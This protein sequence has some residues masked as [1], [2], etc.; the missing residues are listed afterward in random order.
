[1]KSPMKSKLRS[2]A[3]VTPSITPYT[4][5]L[6]L[7]L[8]VFGGFLKRIEPSCLFLKQIQ[9]HPIGNMHKTIDFIGDLK[10]DGCFKWHTPSHG[11][12]KCQ[13]A[14]IFGGF[15]AFSMGRL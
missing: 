12:Q 15:H 3:F 1:M 4:P 10:S 2:W 11:V 7:S 9:C 14:F 8:K 6:K 13:K 5:L